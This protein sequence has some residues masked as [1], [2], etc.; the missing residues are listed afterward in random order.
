MRS[1]KEAMKAEMETYHK[2][3]R[4]YTTYGFFLAIAGVLA[5]IIGLFAFI[6]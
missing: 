2:D 6:I 5:L 1:Q 4:E 3:R